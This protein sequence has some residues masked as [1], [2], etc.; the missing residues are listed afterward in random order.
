MNYRQTRLCVLACTFYGMSILAALF[1][2]GLSLSFSA[3]VVRLLEAGRGAIL[4]DMVKYPCEERSR[5]M[6][7]T[8]TALACTGLSVVSLFISLDI[9]RSHDSTHTAI[10][11][12]GVLVVTLL[13]QYAAVLVAVG[14][15]NDG[16][17]ETWG[18][19]WEPVAVLRLVRPRSRFLA[20]MDTYLFR[21]SP[22]PPLPTA[23]PPP[24]HAQQASP[25]PTTT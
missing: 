15:S 19:V 24:K 25:P 11:D 13:L 4:L 3:W 12:I 1:W 22:P 18:A 14:A 5:A 16:A 7:Y 8:A 2:S 21:P 9:S 20:W 10:P 23:I 6:I 17:P